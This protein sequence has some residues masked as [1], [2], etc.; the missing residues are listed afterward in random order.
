MELVRSWWLRGKRRRSWSAA[1]VCLLCLPHLI[2]IYW[3]HTE[4]ANCWANKR[5]GSQR[6]RKRSP[7]PPLNESQ[8]RGPPPSPV[9]GKEANTNSCR[10]AGADAVAVATPVNCI[11]IFPHIQVDFIITASAPLTPVL[12]VGEGHAQTTSSQ[13]TTPRP[14]VPLTLD[15]QP[16]PAAH[17]TH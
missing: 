9:R 10:V 5:T 15:A 16:S 8:L 7:L 11:C 6:K 4:M 1:G 3:Q 2:K 14:P 12:V 13:H 17:V